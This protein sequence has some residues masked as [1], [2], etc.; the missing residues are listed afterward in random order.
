MSAKAMQKLARHSTVELTIGRYPNINDLG[1]A[2]QQMTP[3]PLTTCTDQTTQPNGSTRQSLIALMDA[4]FSDNHCE[5]VRTA[6]DSPPTNEPV[7]PENT[8]SRNPCQRKTLD[9][10]CGCLS[11]IDKAERQGFEPWVPL[12]A[13][14]FSRPDAECPNNQTGNDLE[15]SHS[16]RCTKCCTPTTEDLFPT[17]L[18]AIVTAWAGLPVH[19]RQ[20]IISL[21][22]AY[23]IGGRE[24]DG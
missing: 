17:E 1:S 21:V 15:Q 8:D 20:A 23:G 19:I 2:V 3:L 5:S 10:D 9:K 11:A 13:L 22:S 16:G 4:G 7:E 6:E 18:S 12:R 24:S 14:R